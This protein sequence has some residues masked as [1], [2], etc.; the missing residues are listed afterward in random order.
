MWVN[1]DFLLGKF[2]G[3]ND[4][5]F[6]NKILGYDIEMKKIFVGIVFLLSKKLHISI[7]FC[8]FAA[9]NVKSEL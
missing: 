1:Y 7:I 5:V 3:N 8:T 2:A 4:S 9:G 6:R